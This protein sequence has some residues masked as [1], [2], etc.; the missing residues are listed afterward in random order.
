MQEEGAED[1]RRTDSCTLLSRTVVTR[2]VLV[3]LGH[4]TERSSHPS[5]TTIA[6]QADMQ[7]RGS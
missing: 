2:Q 3:V 4:L 7:V 5:R 6:T 1:Q